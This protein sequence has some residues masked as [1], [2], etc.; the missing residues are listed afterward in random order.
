MVKNSQ[1]HAY[2]I[3]ERPLKVAQINYVSRNQ[4]HST[5]KLNFRLMSKNAK[6]CWALST[7]FSVQLIVFLDHVLLLAELAQKFNY[8]KVAVWL[9]DSMKRNFGIFNFKSPNSNIKI[10]S[11]LPVEPLYPTPLPP[12]MSFQNI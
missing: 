12:F 3:Y 4:L 1:K 10:C 7:K 5:A 11:Y 8:F 6:H 2:V 9:S